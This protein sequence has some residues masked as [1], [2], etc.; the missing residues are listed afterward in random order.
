MWRTRLRWSATAASEPARRRPTIA[1]ADA[2]SA[3]RVH[4]GA[5]GVDL[6]RPL[7]RLGKGNVDDAAVLPGNH[8]IKAARR[9]EIN[10]ID[11]ES[12]GHQPVI[13]GGLAAALHMTQDG[14][15]G[16]GPGKLRDRLAENLT[17]P[18]IGR[19]AARLLPADALPGPVRNRLRDNDQRKLR[20]PRRSLSMCAAT[21]SMLSGISGIRMM[22]APP[23][24]PAARAMWPASPPMTSRT[25]TRS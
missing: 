10:G 3:R 4:E 2:K 21:T 8:A 5:V 25:I 13:P 19:A 22:S 12:R 14:Y 15:P 7:D 24:M 23:A 6:L 16:L 9:N 1:Q 11:A 17:D 18:A 20:P